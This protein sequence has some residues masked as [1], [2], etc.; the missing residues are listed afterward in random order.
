M[1]Q[2][3]SSH[4]TSLNDGDQPQRYH[5]TERQQPPDGI[6]SHSKPVVTRML[7]TESRFALILL[8]AA[9]EEIGTQASGI[10]GSTKQAVEAIQT[11][12]TTMDEIGKVTSVIASTVEQQTAATHEITG[13][14]TL[15]AQGF[16]TVAADVAKVNAAISKAKGVR[17]SR[18]WLERRTCRGG[19]A[20]AGFR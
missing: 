13:N 19:A 4:A 6:V 9:T 15:A 3:S 14:V 8:N 17:K 18:P 7:R 10:Q 16:G 5:D 12:T 1:S 11:I 20:I 2:I